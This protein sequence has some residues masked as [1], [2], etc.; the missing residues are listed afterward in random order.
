MTFPWKVVNA[1][2][3]EALAHIKKYDKVLYAA[4]KA[5]ACKQPRPLT[6]KHRRNDLFAS[7]VESVVSQQ[8]SV[9]A[10]DTIYT[11]LKEAAGGSI[12]PERIASTPELTLRAAGLSGA[13]VKTLKSLSLAITEG[14]LDLLALK[15][16]S[17][18]AATAALTKVW[19][20]GPWTAEM[21]LIFALGAPDIFSPGDLAIA[22][23]ME[24]VFGLPKG[25]PRAELERIAHAWSPHRSYACR[26]LWA[27]RD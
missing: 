25:A 3:V 22:R 24:E 6:P 19:G 21:F 14:S 1:G 18:E 9:R 7:L 27:L 2:D 16:Y 5:R 4:L 23:S 8:L 13:K 20:I 26:L 12:T 11:R 15:K 10:S 17:P